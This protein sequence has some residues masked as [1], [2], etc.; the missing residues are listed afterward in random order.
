MNSMPERISIVQQV[1]DANK[2]HTVDF[3]FAAYA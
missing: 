1:E 2:T 3:N